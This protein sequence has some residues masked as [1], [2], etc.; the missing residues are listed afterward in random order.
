MQMRIW[1]DRRGSRNT[2]RVGR[3][4]STRKRM[5]VD[6]GIDPYEALKVGNASNFIRQ[7]F[8]GREQESTKEPKHKPA[9]RLCFGKDEQRN[10]RAFAPRAEVRDMKLARTP[11]EGRS[12]T[13][14]VTETRKM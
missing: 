8:N 2:L 14:S 12:L 4:D 1:I 7:I 9:K 5:R 10:G 3:A 6:V 11:P 13:T